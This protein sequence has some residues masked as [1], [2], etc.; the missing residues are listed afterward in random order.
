MGS[1]GHREILTNKEPARQPRDPHPPRVP[2]YLEHG[3]PSSVKGGTVIAADVHDREEHARRLVDPETYRPAPCRVCGRLH[4]HGTRPRQ[5]RGETP[6]DVRR[7]RCPSCGGVV[8]VLPGFLARNLWRT[9]ATVEAI[10]VIA[11]LRRLWVTVAGRT[12]RRWRARLLRA[13]LILLLVLGALRLSTL[14]VSFRIG[15]LQATPLPGAQTRA[16]AW[17]RRPWILRV[18]RCSHE[19]RSS[20]WLSHPDRPSVASRLTAAKPTKQD[21]LGPHEP[22]CNAMDPFTANT[23]PLSL[24]SLRR[25]NPRQEPSAV[26]P[27]AR[28]CAGGG[29][30]LKGEGPSLPRSL[31]RRAGR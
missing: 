12:Q 2:V 20:G 26:V 1:G 8:Q 5:P 21:D 14:T 11:P 7:Y 4:G 22:A 25:S 3:Y 28:I 18:P 24:G 10:C 19:H 6:I 23:T 27:L 17:C 16:M 30:S 13:A 29:P 15:A 9:W 31:R